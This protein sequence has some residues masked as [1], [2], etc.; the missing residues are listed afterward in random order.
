M[1]VEVFFLYRIVRVREG[2]FDEGRFES[3]L[4]GRERVSYEVRE[5]NFRLWG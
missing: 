5:E 2:V 1:E 3:G 4:E